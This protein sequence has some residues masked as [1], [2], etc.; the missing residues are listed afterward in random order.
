MSTSNDGVAGVVAFSVD[1]SITAVLDQ[2]AA[3]ELLSRSAFV[4]RIVVQ[5][6]RAVG[7][8]K[9]STPITP[10]ARRP[11]GFGDRD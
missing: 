11:A 6:L 4:R 9:P 5:H 7:E 3:R 10:P 1:P 2:V 8:I